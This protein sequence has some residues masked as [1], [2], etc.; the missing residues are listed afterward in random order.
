MLISSEEEKGKHGK[1]KDHGLASE[2][3]RSFTTVMLFRHYLFNVKK[4]TILT[5]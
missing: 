3:F 5:I 4:S 1:G 2:W